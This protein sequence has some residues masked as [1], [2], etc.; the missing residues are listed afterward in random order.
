M[1]HQI[2]TLLDEFERY[3]SVHLDQLCSALML[4]T[5]NPPFTIQRISQLCLYPDVYYKSVGKYL[6]AVERSLLVT[7][8]WDAFPPLPASEEEYAVNPAS[9]SSRSLRDSS[10]PLFSPIPFLHQDARSRSPSPLSMPS[11]Q[12][13]ATPNLNSSPALGLVDELDSPQPGH[14]SEKPT[15]ISATTVPSSPPPLHERF[16]KGGTESGQTDPSPVSNLGEEDREV[17]DMVLDES[18]GSG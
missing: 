7:S 10:S 15:A 12:T 3:G 14:L 18:Q 8:T 2:F 4:E 16:V 5:R 6:R 11:I 17:E 1:K 13:A 9:A